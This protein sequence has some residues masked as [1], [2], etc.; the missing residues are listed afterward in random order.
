M[1]STYLGGA[2]TT[3]PCY[4]VE[5]TRKRTRD[6]D[7]SDQEEILPEKKR[8]KGTTSNTNDEPN[9]L[10]GEMVTVSDDSPL[11]IADNN[12]FNDHSVSQASN[13]SGIGLSGS[14]DTINQ[15]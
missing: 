2:T 15:G 6:C 3:M 13:T 9:L 14:T 5:A 7:S 10:E 11:I 12:N 4:E 8:E 1:E